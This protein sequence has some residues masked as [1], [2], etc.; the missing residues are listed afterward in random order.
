[1]AAIPQSLE[2]LRLSGSVKR[3]PKR[4]AGRIDAPVPTAVLGFPPKHLSPALKELWFEVR[5]QALPGTL[6]NSDRMMVEV[7][8]RLIFKSRAETI[9]VGENSQLI[10]CLANLGMSPSHRTRVSV[11]PKFVRKDES[12]PFAAFCT[13][14]SSRN[15]LAQRTQ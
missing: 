11:D 8:V 7:L 6:G 14:T 15:D 5:S 2:K 3:D 10:A 9:T 4:Y 13:T 1:M 12:S